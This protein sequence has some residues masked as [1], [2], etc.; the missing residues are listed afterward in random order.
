MCPLVLVHRCLWARTSDIPLSQY[1]LVGPLE[2]CMF[3]EHWVSGPT[4]YFHI[5]PIPHHRSARMHTYIC[6]CKL[7]GPPHLIY[8][9][10]SMGVQ[11][12][13]RIVHL[14]NKLS[15]LLFL[16]YVGI[17]LTSKW[18]EGGGIDRLVEEDLVGDLSIDYGGWTLCSNIGS[19]GHC[20]SPEGLWKF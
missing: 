5:L 1:G 11:A 8:L 13:S 19:S 7:G 17:C 4:Q 20:I 2:N 3:S 14:S 10:P 9:A 18:L 15:S 16:W 12:H 6:L